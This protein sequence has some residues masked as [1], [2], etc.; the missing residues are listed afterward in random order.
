MWCFA[1]LPHLGLKGK[2]DSCFTCCTSRTTASCPVL[3]RQPE[4]FFAAAFTLL[5]H[6]LH[7]LLLQCLGMLETCHPLRVSG[8]CSLCLSPSATWQTAQPHFPT[9]L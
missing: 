1:T 9:P 5:S 8:C 6:M 3:L 2:L 4:I 7:G